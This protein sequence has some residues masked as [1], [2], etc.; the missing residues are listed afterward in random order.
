MPTCNNVDAKPAFSAEG[1]EYQRAERLWCMA[2]GIFLLGVKRDE[3]S[4]FVCVCSRLWYGIPVLIDTVIGLVYAE[5]I[6]LKGGES[7]RLRETLQR[8]ESCMH[9]YKCCYCCC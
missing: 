6:L 5:G 7:R 9:L 3:V 2:E 1:T 8:M 4:V